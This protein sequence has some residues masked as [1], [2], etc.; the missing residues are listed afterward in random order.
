MATIWRVKDGENTDKTDQGNK[1]DIE[2]V[3]SLLEKYTYQYLS[4]TPPVFNSKKPTD[5]YRHIVIQIIDGDVLN[6]K[7]DKIGFYVVK[8]LDPSLSTFLFK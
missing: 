5:Y 2:K 6:N 1:I 7:F 4:E 3:T 8:D